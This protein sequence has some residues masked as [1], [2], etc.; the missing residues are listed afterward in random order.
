MF[1]SYFL[2][3]GVR[4]Y[5]SIKILAELITQ[6]YLSTI[7]HF[8]PKD[9]T[10]KELFQTA[11]LHFTNQFDYFA[12]TST[13]G[14]I[15]FCLAMNY[16][17][18]DLQEIYSKSSYYFKRNYLGPYI[19]SKYDPSRI[20]RKIDEI[21]NG[22]RLKDGTT[23]SAENTTLLDIRNILNPDN[24][25]NDQQS[26]SAALYHGNYLEFVND[27]SFR[28]DPENID[29][30]YNFHL[31]KKEKVLLITAYN[32]TT[33]SITV[34]NTSYAKYWGYRIA[35]VLKATMAAPTYFP[36]YEMSNGKK[37]NGHFVKAGA[38]ELHID[39]GV[40]A[41]DPELAALW[42]IRMQWKKPV[43]YHLLSIG[44]GCYNTTLSSS[45]RGGYF[46]W[47]L[48]KGFLINTMM[49]ATRSFIE[50]IG[51]NLAKF[52]NMKRMKLNYRMTKPIDLDDGCFVNK[53]DEEWEMLKTEEDFRSFVYF[54]DKYITE[55]N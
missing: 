20:H 39:G 51:G 42:A 53:F 6:K 26:E 17:I 25:I 30:G 8:N 34:F 38:L 45:T 18:L 11:Q 41:N 31:A 29:E 5:M 23:L 28:E 24:V 50:T 19:Y 35:D 16:S 3:I 32:T 33:N 52:D 10:H 36:P 37:V 43:N 2:L 21:I 55:Q 49:D 4:G 47:I 54:Y 9:S 14:L 22:I 7:E 46:D 44:T 15:S 1:S 27:K 12:G 13:G 40:F 48:N